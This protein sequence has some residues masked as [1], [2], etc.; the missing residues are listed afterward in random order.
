V[1]DIDLDQLSVPEVLA[2]HRATLHELLLREIVRT[3][4]PPQGD[5][6]EL[7]VALAYHGQIAPNSEKAWDVLTSTGRRL[8]VKSQTVA[9][10]NS[11][12]TLSAIRSFDFD[13]VVVVFL[14]DFDLSVVEARELT[15]ETVEAASR[16]QNHVNAFILTPNRTL[17]D[18]GL[19]VTAQLRTA[20]ENL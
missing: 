20:A 17:M 10:I 16:R 8:Q 19:D 13:A 3:K 15:R 6:A 12:R 9:N 1:S 5:Y 7:L 4:N 14:S 11:V 2:L 18:A